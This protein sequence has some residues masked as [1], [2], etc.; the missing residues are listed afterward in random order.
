MVEES[1][2]AASEG[3]WVFVA[4]ED[5]RNLDAA[6]ADVPP[7]ASAATFMPRVSIEFRVQTMTEL[8]VQATLANDTAALQTLRAECCNIYWTWDLV[9]ELVKLGHVGILNWC[10][11]VRPASIAYAN[12]KLNTYCLKRSSVRPAASANV[13]RMRSLNSASHA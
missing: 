9:Q 8:F 10:Y 5:V 4:H 1:K 6:P 3:E 12:S 2:N 7:V 13:C 11:E